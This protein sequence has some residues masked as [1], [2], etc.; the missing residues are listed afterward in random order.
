[1]ALVTR[2]VIL[3]V[4]L[5]ACGDGSGD[6]APSSDARGNPPSSGVFATAIRNV[7]IEIDYEAG[8]EPFTG[9][10]I[11][12]GDTFDLSVAN[13]DR[14]FAGTKQLTVP[15][16]TSAME[17]IG[18]VTD[19][20]LTV[21]D[22]LAL[23]DQH[24]DRTT[25]GDTFTYYIVFL[26]GHFADATGPQAG[27]LGV[28]LGNTG[29][30]AMF[31]DV[32]RGSSGLPNISR[33][34]EQVTMIHEL[35]HAIGLVDNGVPMVASHKDAAHGAHCTNERCAMYWQVEGASAAAAYAQQYV[36]TSNT[37]IFAD[38]CLAD[39]DALTGGP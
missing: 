20:E 8:Q 12:F 2:I 4:L 7:E 23:A 22:I 13:L 15:R 26:S 38:E 32:I 31:K 27:V 21:D 3:S 18:A 16:T 17:D 11:G 6:D 37:I 35:G 25:A 36:L 5:V 34:V 9:P 14:L 39:V 30:I 28:A 10:M 24:R 1:M 33:F 29:V 19:E